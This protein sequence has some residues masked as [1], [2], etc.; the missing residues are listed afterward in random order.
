MTVRQTRPD[1]SPEAVA[2]RQCAA[3]ESRAA[4]VRQ[5]YVHD[6]ELEAGKARYVAG[7]LTLVELREQILA[8][9]RK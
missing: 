3:D 7:D 4:N 1:R 6:E 5:G 9:Y 8:R 2:Q